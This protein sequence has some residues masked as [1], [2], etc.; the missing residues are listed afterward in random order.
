M[1]RFMAGVA[2]TLFLVAAG[3]FWWK[4]LARADDKTP[5]PPS[6]T[7]LAARA[8][9]AEAP[10]AAERSRETKRYD[11]Y[12]KNRDEVMTRDEYLAPRRKAWAKLDSDGNGVLSFEEWSAKTAAKFTTADA[13]RSASLSRDEFATT[14]VRKAHKVRCNQNVGSTSDES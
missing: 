9:I 14:R 12:D 6:A 13:D 8:P 4:S 10:P 11:R 1:L 3:M 2:A 7:L 5:L